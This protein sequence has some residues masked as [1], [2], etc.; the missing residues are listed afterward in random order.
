MCGIAGILDP[1]R[2]QRASD[3][4]TAVD[5]MSAVLRHRGPDAEGTWVDADAGIALGHRRLSILDISDAG[6]QP[7]LSSS[8][9]YVLNYNGEIYN[10]PAL[11]AMLSAAG[12]RFRGHSD[13]EVLVEAIDEWG[14]EPALSAVN[15]MFAFALWDRRH[16][17]LQL[18]R[19]RLGEK[20][21]FYGWLGSQ[22]AFGSE[23][24]ALRA[25]PD[26]SAEIDRDA[27]TLFLRF[28][29]VPAPWSIFRGI[30]KLPP[31]SILT[32]DP[33]HSPR[34]AAPVPY[35]SAIDAFEHDDASASV[36]AKDAEDRLEE[37]LRD[38]TTMRMRSD[39]PF[40]AFLSG[41]IDSST[42]VA[43]MQAGS[44]K[45]VHTFTIANTVATYDEADRARA[46]ARH[47]GTH[48]HELLVTPTDALAVIPRLSEIYDEPFS[49]TSQVPTVLLAELARRE[50][51][52]AL[53]GDG[54]DEVFGGYDRYRWVPRTSHRLRRIPIGARRAAG[55]ALL[56]VPPRV[57]DRLARPLPRRLRPRTP[58][59]KLAKFAAI[60]P[61]SSPEAMYRRLVSHWDEP[62][63]VVID[64]R[65]PPFTADAGWPDVPGL[66]N[67]MMALDTVTYLP[68]DIL[69]KLDRATMA[70]G[71]EARVPILDHRVVEFAAAL[72]ADAKIKGD[73]GKLILRRVLA[74]HLPERI[75]DVPK[76]GFGVPL[77]DWLR[78]P[79]RPW[80]EDLLAPARLH[81]EG[82]L[83]PEPIRAIWEE[84][85]SRR[86]DHE[87]DLWDVLMFQ[88]WL[89]A[90]EHRPNT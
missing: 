90:L 48:H 31:A 83:R 23:L 36:N 46:V 13:T 55:R 58:S 38:A 32:V 18:V 64:G 41:G 61:L 72:P 47:L 8:G 76:S 79:L 52:V 49:D 37:L 25:H 20:P 66:E 27:L 62:T 6:A 67:Q 29:C 85:L 75:F 22:F 10:A 50:V 40:G 39:V 87:Y 80:A 1:A 56:A 17:R 5:A 89:E 11:A 35:W 7:M 86:R 45:P 68:D 21:L 59:T 71:L 24:K 14:L 82:Y 26:F 88:E 12:R 16:R 74:R 84:H 9:R 19:D 34:I 3:L 57:W 53:S 73:R 69:V 78:G 60:A 4:V 70:V 54:G 42:I 33:A 2:S 77:G 65:E 44:S 63:A 15:G 51:T 30:Q 28:S 43:L 81:R